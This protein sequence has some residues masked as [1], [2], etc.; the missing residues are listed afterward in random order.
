MIFRVL[1]VLCDIYREWIQHSWKQ[2]AHC[3]ANL[4]TQIIRPLIATLLVLLVRRYHLRVPQ[5][6]AGG[7][8]S[9][10]VL[11][12]TALAD[13]SGLLCSKSAWSGLLFA[14]ELGDLSS[15]AGSPDL[16]D[17]G[18]LV[19]TAASSVDGGVYNA[20]GLLGCCREF[21]G[22]RKFFLNINRSRK[23]RHLRREDFNH[24]FLPHL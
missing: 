18:A 5:D 21:C 10:R 9:G 6:T 13:V 11:S 16:D 19:A 23:S 24:R 3:F 17:G 7:A 2:N 4:W 1:G 15:E 14:Y 12:G 22:R 8:V 20:T